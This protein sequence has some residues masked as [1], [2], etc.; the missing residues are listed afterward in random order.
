MYYGDS[1]KRGRKGVLNTFQVSAP[2][3]AYNLGARRLLAALAERFMQG[4]GPG[5]GRHP[6]NKYL[7]PHGLTVKQAKA[8][9][10]HPT[11]V[12]HNDYKKQAYGG[13]VVNSA[14]RFLLR[15]PTNHFDVVLVDIS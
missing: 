9:P 4:G 6:G 5:S 11:W 10:E 2:Q 3:P 14:G 15:E 7:L 1:P 12:K 8:L 13:V